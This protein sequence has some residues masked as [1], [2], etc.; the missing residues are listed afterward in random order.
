MAIPLRTAALALGLGILTLQTAS[1]AVV[2]VTDCTAPPVEVLVGKT[3]IS[4]GS[5]D[6]VL[7]CALVP[8][9]GTDHILIEAHD[10]LIEAPG[11]VSA[12]GNAKTEIDATGTITLRQTNV[13]S[14]N[15]NASLNLYAAG[16]VLIQDSTVTNGNPT[17]GGDALRIACTQTSPKCTLTVTDST[18]KS[19]KMYLR[20]VGDQVYVKAKIITN[21][22][23]DL[24]RMETTM[25]SILL[26]GAVQD[27]GGDCCGFG[28]GG[29]TSIVSGNEGNL[30][31]AAFG[32]ID[33]SGANILVAE[34]ICGVSG[35]TSAQVPDYD[36]CGTPCAG[37]SA[38]AVPA[39]I[40]ITD[41]SV[42]NDFAKK[43]N[44]RFCAD[45]TRADVVIE[46]A[47]LIDDDT[48]AVNDLSTLNGCDTLPRSGCPNV[49]GTADTDS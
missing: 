13:E 29:G 2:T 22:P 20:T 9:P 3:Q 16:N 18:L 33:L 44:I 40:D 19:R 12:P 34:N 45:E 27:G 32:R 36:V 24:V 1:A 46:G 41:G 5:D 49:A 48:S 23:T 31:M 17:S 11:S 21:S 42:R 10:V 30:F 7:H 28:G 4:I 47:V 25:G 35:L 26:G 39:D 6:L 15:N 38:S 8:L 43:G 37:G 14:T